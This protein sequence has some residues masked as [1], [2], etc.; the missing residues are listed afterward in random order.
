MPVPTGKDLNS[1]LAFAKQA[2]KE[3]GAIQRTAFRGKL[4]IDM[5]AARNWVTN[6]DRRCEKHIVD[7]IRKRFPGHGFC[8]EEG[9]QS[10]GSLVWV[11]DPLDA[12]T[13]FARGLPWFCVSI[14]LTLENQPLVGVIYEPLQDQLF[15]ASKRKGAFLN[16]KRLRVSS[17]GR[18]SEAL[19]TTGFPYRMNNRR[20]KR[21]FEL[22]AK[23]IRQCF[24]VRRA[25]SAALDLAHVAAGFADG[26]FEFRLQPW[27]VAAG[28]L[29]IREAG[30]IA[31]MP[32]D[33][34]FQ[35]PNG[36]TIATNKRL[37]RPLLRAV[38]LR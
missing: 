27:D 8:A 35:V 33:N 38:G 23:I 11:I 6:V 26:H 14:A 22:L 13:N 2:A 5:K 9:S 3:A 12:T 24:S 18:M 17:V 16:G 19:I 36:F 31:R 15:W 30:G 10:T 7:A 34:L 28:V 37:H 4:K 20:Q 1:Y 32:R 29:M 25:G 21:L